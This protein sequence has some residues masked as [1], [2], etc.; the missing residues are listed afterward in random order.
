VDG[1][2]S[3]TFYQLGEMPRLPVGSEDIQEKLDFSSV[4]ACCVAGEITINYIRTLLEIQDKYREK[5]RK[6]KGEKDSHSRY[7]VPYCVALLRFAQ[8]DPVFH[9]GLVFLTFSAID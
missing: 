9:N 7:C 8:E 6:E 4:C 1:R 2:S 5:R 3:S